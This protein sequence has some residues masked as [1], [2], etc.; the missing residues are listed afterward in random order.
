MYF[1]ERAPMLLW[2]LLPCLEGLRFMHEQGERHGDVRPDHVI[3]DAQT[4]LFR[5]IDFDFDFAHREAPFALDILGVGN[6]IAMVVGKGT[7]DAHRLERDPALNGALMRLSADDL[8]VVERGQLMNLR[9]A[10][11]YIP[12]R[13][14][15]VLLHF[16]SGAEIFYETISEVI[17][18]LGDAV[19][20]L[21]TADIVGGEA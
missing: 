14:N 10:Y 11:P 3:I 2:R 5:W 9:K 16:S 13:L 8:S 6:I 18:D 15:R 17:E 1:H 21:M 4:G 7:M 12:G 19:S 20:Q